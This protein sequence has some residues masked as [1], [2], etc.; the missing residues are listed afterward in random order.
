MMLELPTID[1]SEV[2][3]DNNGYSDH[4]HCNKNKAYSYEQRCLAWVEFLVSFWQYQVY[5][6]VDFFLDYLWHISFGCLSSSFWKEEDQLHPTMHTP[7]LE[8]AVDAV[9]GVEKA[10]EA[11]VLMLEELENQAMDTDNKEV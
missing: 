3:W 7:A 11:E 9:V 2:K 1:A 6:F 8:G 5:Y 4:G 10:R